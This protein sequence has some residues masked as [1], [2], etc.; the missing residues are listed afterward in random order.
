MLHKQQ[1]IL[2]LD[3]LFEDE[4]IGPFVRSIQIDSPYQQLIFEGV[5]TETIKEEQ[6]LVTFT[7]EGYFHYIL[8]EVLE[9]QT[10]GGA[11]PL[12]EL[13]ENNQLRGITE[14]VEKCLVRDVEKND[15][16]R[17]MWLIKEGGKALEVNVYPLTQAFLLHP[18]KLVFN[19]L[20]DNP[21]DNDLITLEKAI[22]KLS[23][24]QKN[25]IVK[26]IYKTFYQLINPESTLAYTILLRASCFL[27]LEDRKSII[28]D[29]ENYSKKNHNISENFGW[30]YAAL[31]GA[32]SKDENYIKSILYFKK[33]MAI[34]IEIF[35]E[36]YSSVAESYNELGVLLSKAQKF[37]E[38]LLN[39]KTGLNTANKTH[40]TWLLPAIYSN[41]GGVYN[42]KSETNK[43]IKNLNISLE[44]CFKQIGKYHSNTA[45]VYSQLGRSY[46]LMS[47]FEK[48]I[49]YYK[50]ALEISLELNHDEH[51]I[52]YSEA[53]AE[54]YM[55]LG[56]Y[57]QKKEYLSN[58]EI[59]IKTSMDFALK[60]YGKNH[61]KLARS[62]NLFGILMYRKDDPKKALYYFKK[63]LNIAKET[64]FSAPLNSMGLCY[65]DMEKYDEAIKF[66][67]KSAR[68]N[69]KIH[70]ESHS[71]M[72]HNYHNTGDAYYWKKEAKKAH[73]YYK[74]AL[75]INL[76]LFNK[77][78]L[79]T[80]AIHYDIAFLLEELKQ[81]NKSIK[82]Y[83]LSLDIRKNNFGE[84]HESIQ[85]DISDLIKLAK[86]TNNF[87]LLPNWIRGK[88]DN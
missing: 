73:Y 10:K 38:A 27:K 61:S 18:I 39:L 29:A 7:V 17:L 20:F 24:L 41:I 9:Q 76:K 69:K 45:A 71:N 11:A 44:L 75:K 14:G 6:V 42:S 36:E 63:T 32:L 68:I 52:V 5:L 47:Q 82:H 60:H 35:G 77:D 56:N 88:V 58:A 53:L 80:A 74:K 57:K 3:D 79:Q 8:A 4:K 51:T 28:I 84:N 87:N 70:G 59:Y 16:S 43:A 50:K 21:T 25:E 62:F 40:G 30:F 19:E 22:V 83:I 46:N 72:V 54:A 13:L 1:H 23:N 33:C 85:D 15:L 78:N 2:L 48:G 86:K 55:H 49:E 64:F 12:K 31:A 81:F 26:I 65:V 67:K 37:D 34:E 66:F